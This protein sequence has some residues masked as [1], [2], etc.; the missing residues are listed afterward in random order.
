MGDSFFSSVGD[1]VAVEGA[2]LEE[3]EHEAKDSLEVVSLEELEDEAKRA[4]TAI[5][6]S[7]PFI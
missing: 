6:E 1:S 2:S 3:L 7:I 4:W 5:T